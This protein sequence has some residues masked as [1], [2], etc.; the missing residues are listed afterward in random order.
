MERSCSSP[1]KRYWI[2]SKRSS[3]ICKHTSL[4]C[5]IGR[6]LFTQIGLRQYSDALRH[7]LGQNYSVHSKGDPRKGYYDWG[8]GLQFI[9]ICFSI[10]SPVV[11]WRRCPRLSL[12]FLEDTEEYWEIGVII[13]WRVIGWLFLTQASSEW[14]KSGWKFAPICVSNTSEYVGRWQVIHYKLISE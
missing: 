3:T 8:L 1:P 7:H 5:F 14:S 9:L 13:E 11:C 4:S 6:T 2:A 10:H 12:H